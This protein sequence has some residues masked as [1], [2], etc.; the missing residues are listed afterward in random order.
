MKLSLTRLQGMAVLMAVLANSTGSVLA[1]YAPYGTAYQQPVSQQPLSQQSMYAPPQYTAMAYQQNVPLNQPT[2]MVPPGPMQQAAQPPMPADYGVGQPCQ[3]AQVQ[4]SYESYSGG[5]ASGNCATPSY[6]AYN[7]CSNGNVGYSGMGGYASCGPR[8]HWFGGVYGLYMDRVVSDDIPLAFTTTTPGVGYYPT[9]TEVVLSLQDIDNDEQGG[10]E[11]RFGATLAAC[12]GA[13]FGGGCA[14]GSSCGSG[15]GSSCGT[16]MLAWE[17]A[18]WGLAEE[19]TRSTVVDVATFATDG[20][21]TYGMMDF[22]GLE[23]NPG[24]GYRPV[25]HYYDFGPPTTDN[26]VPADI[27]IRSVYAQSTFSAQNVEVNLLRLPM[28]GTGA[29]V[30]GGGAC[31]GCDPCGG[32]NCGAGG[33]GMRQGNW[34]PYCG[35]RCQVTS[36]LGV[37]YMRFDENFMFRS[38]FENMTTNALGFLAYNAEA[39]N[40]LVGFQVGANGAYYM[41]CAGRFALHCSTNAGI[42][43]NRA[44]V[45]Q[46][47]DSPTGTVRFVNGTQANFNLMNTDNNVAFLGELRLGTSYQLTCNCRFYGGYRALGATGVALAANQMPTAFITPAQVGGIDSNGSYFIHGLQSGIEFTY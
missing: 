47:M 20:N 4:P 41:G 32:G 1:Q 8:R 11:V 19:T 29:A 14:G 12:G 26:T 39:D 5:C 13:G 42:Y 16:G 43:G 35:P 9:D 46:W 44:E 27:E 15:C 33:C 21:R 6:G 2:E 10:A 25:N 7:Y 34:A 31:G 36:L 3:Q 17:A 37:R 30:C 18:Y 45:N 24:T 40:H 38:D 28:I 23:Y 22:R